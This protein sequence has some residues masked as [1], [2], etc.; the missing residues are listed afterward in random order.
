V[1]SLGKKIV[2]KA[3]MSSLSDGA[4]SAMIANLT[5]IANKL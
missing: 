5:S 2:A 1:Q 3:P 4:L